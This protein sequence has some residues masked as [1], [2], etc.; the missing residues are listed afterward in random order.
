MLRVRHNGSAVQRALRAT[1]SKT[2]TALRRTINKLI[3]H[4]H[5]LTLRRLSAE[6]GLTQRRLREYVSKDRAD[7]TSMSAAVKVRPHTFNIASFPGVKQIRRGS[8]ATL[9]AKRVKGAP[10]TLPR[11]RVR[12]RTGGVVS[13]AWGISRL[14]GSAFLIQGG[15]TA[16][17]RVGKARYPIKPVFGPRIHAEFIK[18]DEE[19]KL[20]V[21]ARFRPT[22]A[23]EL[24]FA[25]GKIGL[26]AT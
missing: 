2:R 1:E 11:F 13:S 23:H 18:L 3:D 15:K 20:N 24:A 10:V 25:L 14:Y 6:T 16:M 7:F 4:S 19:L 8:V 12:A 21:Q 9:G 26:K 22:L 17:V 5:T